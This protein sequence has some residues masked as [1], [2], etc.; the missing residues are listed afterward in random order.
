MARSYETPLYGDENVVLTGYGL[1]D[2]EDHVA[3]EDD[4]TARRLG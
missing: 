2:V 1:D 3:G 4:E